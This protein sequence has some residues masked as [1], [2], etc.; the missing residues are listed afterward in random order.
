M[1]LKLRL[2][3]PFALLLCI[4]GMSCPAFAAERAPVVAIKPTS[5]AA[6][7]LLRYKFKVG[8]S[9][10]Y[11]DSQTTM[12]ITVKGDKRE[13]NIQKA[14]YE[15]HLQV[16]SEERPGEEQ[17]SVFTIKPILDHV[18]MS[19]QFDDTEP[20]T[21]DSQIKIIPTKYFQGI[22]AVIGK[23]IWQLKVAASG[24]LIEQFDLRSGKIKPSSLQLVNAEVSDK[25]SRNNFF[26]TFPTEPV[27]VGQSWK[28]RYLGHVNIPQSRRKLPIKFL[29]THTLTA[30][31]GNVASISV[32]TVVLTVINNPKLSV[33]LIQ[34]TP[35]SEIKFDIDRGIMLERT[36]T[37]DEK[38]FSF[39]GANSVV[40]VESLRE[41]AYV[42]KP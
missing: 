7:Y 21:Y 32:R 22:D 27:A 13:Q 39:S 34:Q 38:V 20:M 1:K 15:K 18:K 19:A 6:E 33:Q 40:Q 29:R 25:H 23:S 3:T 30:V 4:S 41:E 42:E 5:A 37:V 14:V 26:L 17:P 12:F 28:K 24:K 35:K 2:L 10:Y 11:K 31:K 36:T 9:L 8:K 16:V